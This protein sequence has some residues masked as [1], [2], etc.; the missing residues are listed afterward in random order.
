M[1]NKLIKFFREYGCY[2]RLNNRDRL[3]INTDEI[4][5]VIGDINKKDIIAIT[6]YKVYL[7][8]DTTVSINKLNSKHV[9]RIFNL[10]E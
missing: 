9:D 2:I 8:D 6:P 1:K 10:F 7:E 3:G 4:G 5:V